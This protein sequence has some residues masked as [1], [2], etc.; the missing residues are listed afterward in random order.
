MCYGSTADM[1]TPT[2]YIASL[3]HTQNHHEHIIWWGPDWCGYTPVVG[4][5]IGAYSADVAAKLNDGEDCIAVPVTVVKALL[6]PEPYYKPGAR[7]YDQPG[8]VV[9][10]ARVVWNAL[11]AARLDAGRNP[12][13]KS[14]PTPFR[15]KRRT[16]TA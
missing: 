15:G 8:P 14:K 1:D 13:A 6:S 10:N 2:Y 7:F 12:L 4:P 11:L 5:N 3:K 16:W 9:N